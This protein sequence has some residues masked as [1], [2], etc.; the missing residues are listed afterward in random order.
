MLSLVE[1]DRTTVNSTS[2]TSAGGQ[3]LRDLYN[4]FYR[5]K[6]AIK[7]NIV[8]QLADFIFDRIKTV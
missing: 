4:T 8:Q 6:I 5:K 2:P 7:L 3:A 1:N